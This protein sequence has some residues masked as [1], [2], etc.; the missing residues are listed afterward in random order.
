R[1]TMPSPDLA[2]SQARVSALIGFWQT[3]LQAMVQLVA[4]PVAAVPP[5][6][7]SDRIDVSVEDSIPLSSDSLFSRRS[8]TFGLTLSL[9][10][11]ALMA[12]LI[13]P[14][15]ILPPA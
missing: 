4:G 3:P 10:S 7:N 2:H 11:L 1:S 8:A 12:P 5:M 15:V 6:S 14:P 9:M 13:W